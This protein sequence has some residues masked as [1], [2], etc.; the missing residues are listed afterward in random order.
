MNKRL[1]TAALVGS[2]GGFVFGYDLGAL[3]ASTQSLRDQ[4]HLS[5]AIFGLTVSASLWGT[6][7]GSLLAGRFADSI[8][9][10]DLIARCSILYALA[11]IGIAFPFSSEWS[12]FLAMR[13]LCGIAIG[14]FTVG[15][16]LYLSEMAPIAQR[17]RLVGLFQLQVGA[18]V[19][20]A[21]SVGSLFANLA[22]TPVLW[23]W[24]LGAGA[25]PAVGLALSLLIPQWDPGLST[26]DGRTM[27]ITTPDASNA[28]KFPVHER[29][30]RWRNRRPLLVAT[31]IAIFNQLSG[32]NIL[33]LYML[34]ILS[35]AG[36]GLSLGHT[37]TV[38]ISC[39][40]L[41]T[42]LL[43][44]GFVDKLG[45]KPLLLLGSVGMAVCLLSF[46]LVIPHHF[47]PLLY[48]A[49]LVAYNA[50][51]AF[52]QGTVV[53]VYLSELFPPGMRGAGQGYGAS[54]HWIANAILVSV[55]P[56]MQHAWSIRTFYFFALMMVL[57]IVVVLV[58]YPETRGTVLGSARATEGAD[59]NTVG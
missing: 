46:G 32:V 12:L 15:C 40:S 22:A 9:R 18:G 5:P 36:I 2:A 20:V 34:D 14:G 55:F 11:T 47:A 42:T 44:V 39:L 38:L 52:S 53:W 35:S 3:S 30:F 26:S 13:F 41:A 50:F 48:L 51:F 31:S 17:G 23:K 28:V 25:I 37:Y 7:G 24:C 57:Q 33:L 27:S 10:R 58:W 1:I 43:G 56:M 49:I 45:R 16:P 19:V 29:L 54:V 59:G 8:G 4:F 6:I 21:F